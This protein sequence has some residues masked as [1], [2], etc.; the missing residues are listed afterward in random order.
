MED[1]IQDENPPQKKERTLL[2]AKV[3]EVRPEVI[4]VRNWKEY[5]GESVLIIFSVILALILTET[6]NKIN[7]N[8]RTDD[9]LHEL[10][11]ELINNRRMETEQ[12]HY[13][14]QVLKNIDSALNNPAVA[15]QF[16]HNGEINSNLKPIAPD[17]V[18]IHDLNNVVWDIAKETNVFSKLDLTTYGLLTDIYD[19]Q[20]RINGAEEKIGA[21]L[22][23]WES[24]KPENLST[25]LI[26]LRDN[27]HGWAVDRAP[28]LLDKYSQA[29]ERLSKY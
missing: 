11:D 7:E 3:K 13:H 16:I 15:A 5:M 2:P 24:R 14:V 10:R 6:F 8:K 27:Y 9:V 26:L 25:T 23:S 19:N 21:V 28:A 17:G 18:L 1:S 22:L 29:I 4:T 20:Q 12:Y